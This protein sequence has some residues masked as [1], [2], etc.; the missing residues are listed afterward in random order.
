MVK[1][2]IMTFKDGKRIKITMN[3]FFFSMTFTK[4]IKL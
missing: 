2:S 3:L 4:F 1:K